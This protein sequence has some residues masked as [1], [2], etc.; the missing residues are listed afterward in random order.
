M[1]S[2]ARLLKPSCQEI[3]RICSAVSAHLLL[4]NDKVHDDATDA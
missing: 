1:W 2:V 3:S 4:L